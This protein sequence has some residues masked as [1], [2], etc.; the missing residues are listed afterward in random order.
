[1]LICSPSPVTKGWDELGT[2]LGVDWSGVEKSGPSFE[3]IAKKYNISPERQRTY[4]Q[5]KMTGEAYFRSLS[6][7]EQRRVLGPAKWLAWKEGKF[8]FAQLAKK[9]YSPVWGAG[10]GAASLKE[11]LGEDEAAKY[12][13]LSQW[14]RSTNWEKVDQKTVAD[15]LPK[16]AVVKNSI[17]PKPVSGKFFVPGVGSIDLLVPAGVDLVNVRVIAGNMTATPFRTAST[18]AEKIGGSPGDWQKLVGIVDGKYYTY[19]IHWVQHNDVKYDLKIK[20][21]TRR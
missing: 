9:T 19:E 17:L 18:W 20:R 10:R 13:R 2:E 8:A 4:L 15:L 14:N 6:A 7:E 11:L 3:E 21:S 16:V 5:R 1:M 12:I